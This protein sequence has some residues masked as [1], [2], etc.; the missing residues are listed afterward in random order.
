MADTKTESKYNI[1]IEEMIQAG[2]GYGHEKAKLNP[3]MKDYVLRQKDRVFVIDLDK[4]AEK[5]EKALDFVSQLRKEGKVVLF[6]GTKVAMRDLVKKVAEETKSPYV[7]DRWIGGTFTNFKE[8]KKRIGY[9]KDLEARV[10][11]ID[12][13]KKYVK[14]ERIKMMKEIERLKIKFDGI[15]GMEQLPDAIFI[16]DAVEDKI[17]L[18]EARQ[19]KIPVIAIAD[20]NVDPTQI[21]FPIPGND[22]AYTS[23]EYVLYKIQSI[24]KGE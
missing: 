19:S 23:V 7:V 8:L 5:L 21:T 11:E 4:T 3:K 18:G 20:T 16:V 12:F 15:K 14:K 22:D 2:L 24:L 13:E 1:S 17:A 9:F 10:K 6:V